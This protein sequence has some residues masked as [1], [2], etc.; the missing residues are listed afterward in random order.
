MGRQHEELATAVDEMI[1]DAPLDAEVENGDTE[2]PPVLRDLGA[3]GP[4][5]GLSA[6]YV[7]DG[8]EVSEKRQL[9][10]GAH[11]FVGVSQSDDPAA[12]SSVADQTCERPR[13]HRTQAGNVRATQHVFQRSVR[14]LMEGAA[15]VV[16]DD[17]AGRMHT[18]G[19]VLLEVD[20][21]VAD[22][23]SSEDD[24]LPRITRIGEDFLVAGHSRVEDDLSAPGSGGGIADAQPRDGGA[25]EEATREAV[26][27]LEREGGPAPL[28]LA[29]VPIRFGWGRGWAQ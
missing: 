23:G 26:S 12:T 14:A 15:A 6:G 11:E 28:G 19:L 8:V 10:R 24:D 18:G 13:V 29:H 5:P 1:E 4:A 17:H 3:G 9:A 27:G 16:A 21:V 2:G 22:V 20:S 7:T 25:A